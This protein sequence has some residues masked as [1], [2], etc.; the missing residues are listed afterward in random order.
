MKK[1]FKISLIVIL[2][3]TFVGTIWFL[4]QKSQKKPVVYKTE[5]PTVMNIVKKTVATGAV[6]PRKEIDIKPRVSGIVDKVFV[7]AGKMVKEGDMIARVKIIPNV[8]NLNEAESRLNRAKIAY[9]NAK[10]EFDRIKKLYDQKVVSLA[11]FQRAELNFN[12]SKEEQESADNNLQLIKQGTSKAMGNATNTIIRA[13]ISGMILNVPVKEGNSVIESNTFNEGTTIATVADM[14]DM[15][16]QGKV[17]E[18]EVGKIKQG[19]ALIVT[20]GAIETDKYDAKLEYISPKGLEEDGAIQFEIKA[21]MKLKPG[22]F[23]RSGYSANADIVLDRKDSVMAIPES[24]LKFEGD[25]AF[26]EIETSPQNFKKQYIKTGLSDGINIEVL[27]GLDKTMKIKG[28]AEEEA[29][30]APP[31]G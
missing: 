18:S 15:I 14:T 11:D 8:V 27:S 17:D 19:M 7:E 20:I 16:F 25:T 21:A 26:V 3:A 9:A 31:Q 28:A 2:L 5:S 12:N 10:T 29:A 1:I 24:L 4:Y 30:A 23:I 13:T 22:S 6:V